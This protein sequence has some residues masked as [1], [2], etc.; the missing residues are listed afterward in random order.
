MVPAAVHEEKA[1]HSTDHISLDRNQK[2]F[3]ALGSKYTLMGCL[4]PS[5]PQLVIF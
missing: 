3:Q 1:K 5:W 2:A 4:L